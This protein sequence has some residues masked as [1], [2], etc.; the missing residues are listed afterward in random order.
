MTDKSPEDARS[1]S[2]YQE[3]EGRMLFNPNTIGDMLSF[4]TELLE[5][6]RDPVEVAELFASELYLKSLLERLEF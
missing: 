3:L 4:N 5:K 6:A 2:F 1:S